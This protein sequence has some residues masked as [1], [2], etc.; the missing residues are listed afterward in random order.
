MAAARRSGSRNQGDLDVRFVI[1]DTTFP[2]DPPVPQLVRLIRS[3]QTAL[4]SN[5]RALKVSQ[6]RQ[7]IK[8][9]EIETGVNELSHGL[10]AKPV[11]WQILNV[12]GDNAVD[13][14]ATSDDWSA[15]TASGVNLTATGAGLLL[16]RFFL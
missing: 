4:W 16:I 2:E 5:I 6:Q 1:H 9:F 14:Y 8:E 15:R 13:L 7:T 10:L 12:V 3:M 11:G